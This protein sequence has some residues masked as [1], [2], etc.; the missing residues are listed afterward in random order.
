M[1]FAAP[2]VRRLFACASA[3]ALVITGTVVAPDRVFAAAV[4]DRQLASP[5]GLFLV[6]GPDHAAAQQFVTED[7]QVTKVSAYLVSNSAAGTLNAEI[8]TDVTDPASAIARSS[9]DI[10]AI[11]GAG[12]GWV[13]F[14]VDVTVTPGQPYYLVVQA[15]GAAGNVVWNGA[16]T[17]IPAALPSWNY[18]V[19]YWGGWQAY[20]FDAWVDYHAAFGV[21]LSGA[22]DCAATNTCYKAVP[23]GDLVAY[24]AGLLGN[25]QTT[26]AVSPVQAYGASYVPE[27]NVL[28]LPDGDWRY[29]P[30]GASQPVTVPAGDPGATAQIDASRSWLRAGTIPGRTVQQKSLSA[31]AL[32]TMHLLTQSNGAVAAAWYGAWTYS[33]P[34]DSAFVAAAL[35]RTGHSDDAYRILTY[36]A[37]TQRAD[38]TWEARTKLDGSGPP[39]GRHWQLDANGWI[40][41]AVW[42]WYQAA[43]AKDRHKLLQALYPT[44]QKAADYAAS[45][46]DDSGLPPAGPD[47]WE[48]STTTPNIGTAAPLL[49]GLHASADLA[50]I[51]GHPADAQGWSDAGDRLA[52]GIARHFAPLG[53]PRT[54]DG[55]HGRDSAVTFMA[56]PFNSAPAGLTEAMSST[57]QALLRPNGG[58]VPGNDPDHNWTNTWTPETTF[59]ALAWSATGQQ[60]NAEQVVT[61]LLEHRNMLGELPEQIDPAGDPASV[62][63]LAWSDALSVLTLSQLD[64]RQ[65]PVPPAR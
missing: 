51:T 12:A 16:R 2:T 28:R 14:P 50:R 36:N 37:Q 22:D 48:V 52:E 9:L 31:R 55:L 62:V 13:N 29:L 53:Y 1:V 61:W 3:L 27:S 39:D 33:W 35:A 19:S 49:A 46:L 20:D 44:V 38:G 11:G 42:E 47:Y 4:Y 30:A 6:N 45:S 54:V 21:D 26:V 15:A 34:R 63:P 58:V 23:P 57:Y 17:A 64:G 59:F 43:P 25:G 18:D 56:P 65:I 60:H 7:A 32:L 40:P 41:W 24:T 10:A 5:T 8:R